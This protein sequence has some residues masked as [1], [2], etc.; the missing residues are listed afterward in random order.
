MLLGGG[1]TSGFAQE[2]SFNS[3]IDNGYITKLME[4]GYLGSA[5]LFSILAWIFAAGIR[6]VLNTRA[7]AAALHVFPLSVM[8][9][10]TFLAITETGLMEKNI[11]T[12]LMTVAVRVIMADRE[13]RSTRLSTLGATGTLP[14]RQ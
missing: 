11:W 9:T 5:I 12:I 8:I 4:F 14:R 7:E 2:M 6:L 1:Y 10:I 3:P 13:A